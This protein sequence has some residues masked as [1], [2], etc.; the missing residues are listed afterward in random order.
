MTTLS[1]AWTAGGARNFIVPNK[2]NEKATVT[3]IRLTRK[4]VHEARNVRDADAAGFSYR[5]PAQQAP[6]FQ[7]MQTI[8]QAI[9]NISLAAR[10]PDIGNELAL[11][12]R[13]ACF[14][15]ALDLERVKLGLVQQD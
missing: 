8:V 7:N 4:Q 2:N 6:A 1:A 13:Y 11:R 14:A 5:L 12:R 3:D 10:C 15:I 9:T